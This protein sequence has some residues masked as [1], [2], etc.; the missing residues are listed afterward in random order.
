MIRKIT[1]EEEGTGEEVQFKGTVVSITG[2][3]WVVGDMTFTVPA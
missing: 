2:D 3:T 1:P